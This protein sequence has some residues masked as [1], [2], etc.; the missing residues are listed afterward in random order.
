VRGK[1]FKKFVAAA[2]F[3]GIVSVV[4][5]TIGSEAADA[6][7]R[8]QTTTTTTAPAP[9]TTS[10]T[11]P[12]PAPTGTVRFGG[13][14]NDLAAISSFESH[15]GKHVSLVGS[16]RS[17][18]W[19][20][21]FPT[22]DA[23]AV[24]AHG[25]ATPLITWEPWNPSNGVNQSAY[26]LSN[27]AAGNFDA[28]LNTWANEIKAYGHPVWLRFAHEMNGNWYPWAVG[29]NGNTAA[30]YVNAWRHVH[31]VF[32]NA[33][34]TNVTWVWNVNTDAG[35][36][37]TP[38]SVYPGGAYVDWM[39]V[40]GYNWGTTQ[41]WGSTWQSPGQVFNATLSALRAISTKPVMIGETASAETGGNKAQWIS[42]F[43]TWMKGYGYLKAFVW[44]DINK[45]VDW[46]IESSSSAQAAFASGVADARYF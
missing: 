37:V 28:M 1:L 21:H 11:A 27:I 38:A 15:A 31:D 10:T 30:D 17:F 23:N 19:D 4:S 9:T 42:D 36:G 29:V 18:Y 20:T 26:K 2:T 14:G 43:F 46:R 40:D 5:G 6:R 33:G 24:Y 22:S 39:G 35:T 32:V 7:V 44:F 3:V 41:S 8:K 45:E 34:V 12:A 13:V 16:Y 25:G